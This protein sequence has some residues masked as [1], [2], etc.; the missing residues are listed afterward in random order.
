MKLPFDQVGRFVVG[1]LHVEETKWNLVKWR[2]LGKLV[3]EMGQLT[4]D[5]EITKIDS[6]AENWVHVETSVA[7]EM[8]MLVV[9]QWKEDANDDGEVQTPYP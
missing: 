2:H 4:V 1:M 6:F 7:D 9:P 8:S 3:V 5:L